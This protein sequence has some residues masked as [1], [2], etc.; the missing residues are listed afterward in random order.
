MR[1]EIVPLSR[2]QQDVLE[3]IWAQKS[4][5]QIAESLD[6]QV[7]TVNTIKKTLLMKLGAEKEEMLLSPEIRT[8]YG[9]AQ[10]A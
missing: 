5:E 6:I 9:Q 3:G 2:R 10:P 8:R 7:V 1:K 4:P